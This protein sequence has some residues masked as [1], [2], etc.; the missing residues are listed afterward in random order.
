MG[1]FGQG[2]KKYALFN[3]GEAIDKD[4]IHVG[5]PECV[6]FNKGTQNIVFY[7]SS[8][9]YVD[10]GQEHPIYIRLPKQEIWGLN[11]TYGK[12][13]KED[14]ATARDIEG[15]Q[16]TYPM[17]T[18]EDKTMNDNEKKAKDVM[19]FF[20]NLGVNIM[21]DECGKEED[22]MLVPSTTFSAF[23]N[24]DKKK[25]M[26][27]AFKHP[28]QF[29]KI[30]NK[31]TNKK[32]FDKTK[33]KRMYLKLNARKAKGK[34]SCSSSIY[35]PGNKKTSPFDL[36]SHK[37]AWKK[38]EA[39]IVVLVDGIYW[40]THGAENSWGASWRMKVHEMNYK[41]GTIGKALDVRMLGGVGEIVD[42]DD[43]EEDEF[44]IP[45]DDKGEEEEEEEEE[46]EDGDDDFTNPGGG[47]DLDEKDDDE[48]ADELEKLEVKK[49]TPKKVV[50]KKTTRAKQMRDNLKKKREMA[51][52]E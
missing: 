47:D 23:L 20:Y 15:F 4:K 27:I 25:D 51:S 33:A 40:G 14:N 6:S 13:V 12:G 2:D 17:T 11:A 21:K 7:S 22:D 44:D 29:P 36:W 31:K 24:A 43:E 9:K 42:G 50:T 18:N 52:A 19:D 5:R 8:I 1:V 48:L 30:E 37:D 39:D 41:P 3:P 10:D 32:T 26:G 38:G 28:F 46:E 35:K 34:F 49:V 16:V 45:G